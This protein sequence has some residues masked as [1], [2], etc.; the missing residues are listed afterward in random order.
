RP[1]PADEVVEHDDLRGAGVDE[2]LDDGRPDGP[3]AA[4]H[5][6]AAAVDLHRAHRSHRSGTTAPWNSR[7]RDAASRM[8]S[9]RRPE[10]QS[11]APAR[12]VLM[13]EANSSIT[14]WSASRSGSAGATMS[15]ER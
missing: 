1:P 7:L 6:E 11:V 14:P 12:P 13:Q 15:P 2:L 8:S 5:E 9:T 10:R 4:G 3:G